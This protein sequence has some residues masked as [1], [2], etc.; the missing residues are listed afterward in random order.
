[1]T[2]LR[3]KKR[4]DNKYVPQKVGMLRRLASRQAQLRQHAREAGESVILDLADGW[5]TG[6]PQLD[7]MLYVCDGEYDEN[8]LLAYKQLQDLIM[9]NHGKQAL[10]VQKAEYLQT[11]IFVAIRTIQLVELRADILEYDIDRGIVGIPVH[12]GYYVFREFYA[13]EQDEVHHAELLISGKMAYVGPMATV[14]E[15]FGRTTRNGQ[16]LQEVPRHAPFDMNIHPWRADDMF[17]FHAIG[18][19]HIDSMHRQWMRMLQ[20]QRK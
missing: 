19:E 3:Q 1:M 16:G 6:D 11:G 15:S 9:L 5:S 17:Q 18:Q 8:V 14:D 13:P 7:F 10:L 2:K 20:K 4:L 12:S